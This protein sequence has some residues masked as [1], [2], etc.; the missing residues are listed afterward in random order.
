MDFVLD[1]ITVN[2]FWTILFMAHA[3]GMVDGG[4]A[5]D[6]VGQFGVE[7]SDECRVVSV[8]CVSSFQFVDGVR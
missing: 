3:L 6:E 7:F 1:Y 8:S 5:S 2:T 4:G